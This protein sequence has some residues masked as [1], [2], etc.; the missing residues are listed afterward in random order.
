M[1]PVTLPWRPRRRCHSLSDAMPV[2]ATTYAV[3]VA[4][5]VATRPAS[6]SAARGGLHLAPTP[7]LRSSRLVRIHAYVISGG[8][9]DGGTIH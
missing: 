6:A 1:A 3:W 7:Y 2:L 4:I 8:L 5:R 9:G